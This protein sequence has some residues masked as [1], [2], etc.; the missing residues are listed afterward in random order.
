MRKFL[1][2]LGALTL[3]MLVLGA[4]SIGSLFYF[5]QKLDA[6]SKAY[7]DDAVAAIGMNWEIA[8]LLDRA[9]PELQ[10]G[11]NP[12]QL[13]SLFASFS[14]AGPLL[15]YQGSSGE[16]NISVNN[17][18]VSV[19]AAYIAKATFRNGTGTFRI[20]LL[21]RN[22]KWQIHN[23]NFDAELSGAQPA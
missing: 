21:K 19:S 14:R 16:A 6:E 18:T 10:A 22:D 11:I 2:V 13:E 9:T 5:G 3:L 17:L 23:F 12:G 7:V 4:A 8:A 15:E 1:Q 20:V